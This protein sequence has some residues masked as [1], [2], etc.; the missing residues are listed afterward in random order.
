MPFGIE[1]FH[2]LLRLLEERP[3]WRAELRRVVLTD[4]LLR[5][6]EQLALA[7]QQTE[8]RFQEL[9]AHIDAL[10]ARVDALTERLDTLTARVD[11]LTAQVD[12]LTAQVDALT[13]R[14]D[15]LTAQVDALTARV[16]ALT[17]QVAT[18]A[19]QVATLAGHVG[20]LRG[21]SLERRYQT[22]VFAY[23]G[24]VLRRAHALTSRELAAL[25]EDAVQA[26]VLSD[27]EAQEVALADV[28]VRG[29]RPTDGS[30]VYLVVEVSVGVGL[31]DVQRAVERAALLA[32]T[33]VTAVPAVAGESILP[34][35]ADA[36]RG[37]RVWQ[38]TD[39]RVVVPESLPG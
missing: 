20:T 15:A 1:D 32:R 29:R 5:L 10:T 34:D 26:N 37:L 39:G 25:V 9:A 8:L 7:R 33:G 17:A 12:A 2:D 36:A 18:L 35:A 13:A 19:A 22:R 23:F 21:E 14:V 11:A 24:R 38:I 4:D 27:E 30:T 3:E 6:P 16:D 31:G 28:V